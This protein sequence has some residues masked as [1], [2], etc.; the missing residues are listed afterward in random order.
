VE[1]DIKVETLKRALRIEEL[2]K[3]TGRGLRWS[4]GKQE[5]Q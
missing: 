5:N 4:P 3:G 1:L 2:P